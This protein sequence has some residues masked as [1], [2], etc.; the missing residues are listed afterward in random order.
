MNT[1]LKMVLVLT[2]VCIISAV[3]LSFLYVKT[4]ARI[5]QNKIMKEIKIKQELIPQAE[6]FVTK[7]LSKNFYIE[8]CYNKTNEL[9]GLIITSS[10]QGYAGEIEYLVAVN[11]YT[12]I[13][14]ISLKILSHKE[15]PGLGANVSKEKFLSQF[16]GKTVNQL[17]LRKET[18]EGK[19][20][21]ITGATITSRAITNSLRNVLSDEKL[22]EY[23]SKLNV[24]TVI[25]A[26]MKPA[27]EHQNLLKG[28]TTFI[29]E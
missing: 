23:V 18:P 20:D 7:T 11:T 2:S 26:K 12:P 15:T 14:I 17:R 3:S 28:T 10:C 9:V 1:T 6:K 16:T 21:S 25:K 13:E 22:A 5:E 8:E 27:V 4:Q 24:S 19:I 29:Q